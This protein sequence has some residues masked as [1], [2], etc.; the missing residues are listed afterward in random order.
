M[1]TRERPIDRGR[2]RAVRDRID[3]GRELRAARQMLGWSMRE[4]SRRSGISEAQISRIERG[5]HPAVSHQHLVVLAA[6]VG[7]DVRLRAFP[8]G[9]PTLDAAQRGLLDRLRRRLRPGLRFTLE[10]PLPIEGDQRAWD[11]IIGGLVHDG[12]IVSMPID[13][14]TR[15]VDHQAQTRRLTLKLRDSGF[16][17]VL[18]L[19]ADT[20]HN[21]AVVAANRSAFAD[22]FPVS[23]RVALEALRA[24]RHPGGSALLLL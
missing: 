18:L 21:R 15:L 16:E 8:G 20:R 19:V 12:H 11:A 6:I 10:V 5:L 23:A 9:D 13:A 2:A 7:L 4:V 17:S 24:G 1:A 22:Q 3:A 14:E